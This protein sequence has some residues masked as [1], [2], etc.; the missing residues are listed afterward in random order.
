MV[1]QQIV[2]EEQVIDGVTYDKTIR[3]LMRKV[4][5]ST[6]Q[7]AVEKFEK[8]TEFV[9]SIRRSKIACVDLETVETLI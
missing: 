8:N 2:T 3:V 9:K 5:A 1:Y 7:F 6:K 4:N